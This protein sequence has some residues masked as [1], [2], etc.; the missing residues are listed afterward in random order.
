MTFIWLCS[1]N[2]M[3]YCS[4]NI[5]LHIIYIIMGHLTSVKNFFVVSSNTFFCDWIL[6]I[7]GMFHD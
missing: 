7:E 5:E 2:A 1:I 3:I 4:I 6:I